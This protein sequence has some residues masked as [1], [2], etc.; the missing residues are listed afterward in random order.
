MLN[1]RQK[2]E[3]Q[4]LKNARRRHYGLE[5]EILDDTP[6]LLDDAQTRR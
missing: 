5:E 4:R 3:L 2:A 6:M 1:E